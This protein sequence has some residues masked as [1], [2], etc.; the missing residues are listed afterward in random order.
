MATITKEKALVT[1]EHSDWDY[2][3]FYDLPESSEGAALE[4]ARQAAENDVRPREVRSVTVE[5]RK[6]EGIAKFEFDREDLRAGKEG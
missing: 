5:V 4:I 2:S 6:D 3:N 1:V